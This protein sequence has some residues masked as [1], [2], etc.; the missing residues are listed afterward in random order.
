VGIIEGSPIF[1]RPASSQFRDVKIATGY[2][3]WFF[4]PGSAQFVHLK[5]KLFEAYLLFI[6][7]TQRGCRICSY[8]KRRRIVILFNFPG[9][10]L[11]LPNHA[12]CFS[13][14]N[15]SSCVICPD[16]NA[17][18][19]ELSAYTDFIRWNLLSLAEWML[20]EGLPEYFPF[21]QSHPVRLH[22]YS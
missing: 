20:L 2:S 7:T 22:Q 6:N 14:S 17:P 12:T 21:C 19:R 3:S 9:L 18:E 4:I 13:I 15:L 10:M 16:L 8:E 11:L 5:Q 1:P